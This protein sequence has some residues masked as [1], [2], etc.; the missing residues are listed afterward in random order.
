[1]SVTKRELIKVVA[2]QANVTQE[3]AGA[4]INAA[5]EATAA[6]LEHGETVCLRDLGT[7]KVCYKK[8]RKHYNVQTE[9]VTLAA[10]RSQVEFEPSERLKARI[11]P[12]AGGND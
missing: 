10:A 1:M 11:N 6:A 9:N 3:A 5:I 4:I 7:L 12:S 2:Q 8:S